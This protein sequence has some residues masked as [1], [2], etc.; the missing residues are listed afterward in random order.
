MGPT[1][2]VDQRINGGQFNP[3]GGPYSLEVGTVEVVLSNDASGY[4]IADAVKIVSC[5]Q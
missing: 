3:L 5:W 4:V 1:V 2:L